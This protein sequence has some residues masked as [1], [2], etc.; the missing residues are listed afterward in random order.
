M[1]LSAKAAESKKMRVLM[2]RVSLAFQAR[3]DEELKGHEVTMAQL[4]LLHEVRERPGG[5]GAQMARACYVTPQ[6]AQALLGKL[7]RRGWVMRGKDA[8]NERLVTARLTEEG[9]RVLGVAE[10]IV[11][12]LEAEIWRGISIAELQAVA[13]VLAR[14]LSNLEE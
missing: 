4:R 8:E 6:S 2:K 9:T 7:V 1:K 13:A 14:G 10:E 11:R 12:R 5:S 3:M